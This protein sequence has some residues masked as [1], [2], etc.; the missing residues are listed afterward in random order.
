M[1]CNNCGNEVGEENIFCGKCG[2]KQYQEENAYMQYRH[3]EPLC[4]VCGS[5]GEWIIDPVVKSGHVLVAFVLMIFDAIICAA[6]NF[7]AGY[8]IILAP[9]LYLIVV[10]TYR[11]SN[12]RNKICAK[13]KS[14]NM[15]TFMYAD[16]DVE[17]TIRIRHNHWLSFVSVIGTLIG[18]PAILIVVVT[19]D[20]FILLVIAGINMIIALIDL[21]AVSKEEYAHNYSK[22]TIVINTLYV[23]L[24]VVLKL[25]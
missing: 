24:L 4:T 9:L 11:S 23:I 10:A 14:A 15:F 12:P 16:K 13:C 8:I 3:E 7:F 25:I 18:M 20:I 2:A 17:T 6:Y 22:Y 1:I 19:G 21:L 5:V